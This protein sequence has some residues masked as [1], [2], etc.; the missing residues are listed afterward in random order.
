MNRIAKEHAEPKRID[1]AFSAIVWKKF[2][3]QQDLN[4]LNFLQE[5]IDRLRSWELRVDDELNHPSTAFFREANAILRNRMQESVKI[6]GRYCQSR[7]TF[8]LK[9]II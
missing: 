2:L 5:D 9:I 8:P 4:K 7:W 3:D 1:D 6:F